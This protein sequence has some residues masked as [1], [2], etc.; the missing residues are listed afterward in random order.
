MRMDGDVDG[1][2]GGEGC[3]SLA[4]LAACVARLGRDCPWTAEQSVGSVLAFLVDE[5][6]EADE[7]W[8]AL[9]RSS[10]TPTHELQTE[11]QS[12]TPSETQ[13][14]IE[15]ELGDVLF[16]ALLA[17]EV[18]SRALAPSAGAGGCA[19]LTLETVASSA[20]DKLR[21]RYPP[22]FDGSLSA[23]SAAE[24][25][26]LWAEGKARE[27][28]RAKTQ[29]RPVDD[30]EDMRGRGATRQLEADGDEEEWDA[31]LAAEIAELD[32][33]EDKE[34]EMAERQ[35]LARLVMEEIAREAA[36]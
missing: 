32:R 9:E 6:S 2:D 35:E 17:V 19:P 15:S 12:E 8:R 31:A 22:L 20:L 3:A 5:C 36:E 14:E 26:R 13:S 29:A 18:C 23:I 33:L 30:S 24:A 21:R 1:G 10:A 11:I 4:E 7:V 25:S 16:N 28:V 34:D 27:S